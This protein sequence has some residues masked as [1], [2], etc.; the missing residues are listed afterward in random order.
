MPYTD[1][2]AVT[3]VALVIANDDLSRT[4]TWGPRV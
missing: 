3:T 4:T 2:D 1:P